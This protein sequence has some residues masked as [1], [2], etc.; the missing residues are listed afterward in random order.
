[1]GLFSNLFRGDTP[2]GAHVLI[3][4]EA[5]SV[6]GAYT[7]AAEGQIPTLLYVR[8]LPIEI[9]EGEIHE[10]A[11]LR[12]LT[13]LGDALIRE[14]APVL[15]RVAG[16]GTVKSILVSIDAPWQQTSVRT[17]KFEGEHPFIFTKELVDEALKN[18]VLVS[19]NATQGKVLCDESIIGT[20]LNGYATHNP[21]GRSVHR[22]SVVVLTS[23]IEQSVAESVTNTFRSLYHTKDIT[24]IG[25][26]SL[27]YQ[28]LR[29][30]FPHE[31]DLL[32][33][34]ATG[35][36]ISISLVRS[37]LLV[38]ITQQHGGTISSPI[39]IKEVSHGLDE[40]SKKNPLPH[41]IFL[42]TRDIDTAVAENALREARLGSLW[43]SDN[44]PKIVSILPSH[45]TAMVRQTDTA[46]LDL[47]LLLMAIYASRTKLL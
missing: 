15:A 4:I 41:T 24:I 45:L 18:N 19:I 30:S 14:G 36:I 25:G 27:R 10:T 7:Y 35:P 8:R 1:M 3:D 38:A 46:V 42:I 9:R 12:A 26:N 23:L 5:E 37:D 6:A 31:H 28:A 39:W 47:P 16:S 40:L 21:Y 32:I 2:A 29:A 43:L 22:A 44:P 11:M 20:L 33:L 34:D 13:I 17:E